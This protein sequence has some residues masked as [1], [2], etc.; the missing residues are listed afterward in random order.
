MNSTVQQSG[1][2]LV[3]DETWSNPVRQARVALHLGFIVA[4]L[5]AG[6]DKYF[7]VLADWSKYLWPI[8]PRIT[9][10]RPDAFMHIAGAVEIAAGLLVAAKPRL[11]GYVVSAW[12]VGIIIN[13]LGTGGYYDIALRDL[14]LALA[15]FALSRLAS[16]AEV[17]RA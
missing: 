2:S 11:G 12:L 10:L 8:V 9:G 13:L 14:G 5:L 15:A 1:S 6:I 7:N 16:T 4:P 17:Q 3:A